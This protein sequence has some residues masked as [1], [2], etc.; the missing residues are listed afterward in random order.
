MRITISQLRDMIA[1]EI[2]NLNE[3]KKKKKPS[4]GLS[5]KQKSEIA[6]KARKGGDI[7]KKGKGFD[8][9]AAKAA[10]RYGSEEAGKRVAAAAMWANAKR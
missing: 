8:A 4:D 3:K 2:N 7:G 9:V 10:K 5:D 6:K 1:E